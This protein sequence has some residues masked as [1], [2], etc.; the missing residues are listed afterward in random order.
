MRR[1][2]NNGQISKNES[3]NTIGK[4][5]LSNKTDDDNGKNLANLCASYN[6]NCANTHFVPKMVTGGILLLGIVMA[7]IS[8]RNLATS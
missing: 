4:W 8:V 3:N 6:L 1:T 7:E 2:D 5:T